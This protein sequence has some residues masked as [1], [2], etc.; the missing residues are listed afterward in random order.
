MFSLMKMYA[1][2]TSSARFALFDVNTFFAML[3]ILSD[4]AEVAGI[5]KNFLVSFA[6]RHY[7]DSFCFDRTSGLLKIAFFVK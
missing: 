5:A 1:A 2:T 3:R 6:I 7:F 4:G